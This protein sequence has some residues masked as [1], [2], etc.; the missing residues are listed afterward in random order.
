MPRRPPPPSQDEILTRLWAVLEAALAM[1]TEK[2]AADR[3][4]EIEVLCRKAA[5]LA[6][7]LGEDPE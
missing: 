3:R 6:R 7:D 1:A 2:A 4:R 5:A